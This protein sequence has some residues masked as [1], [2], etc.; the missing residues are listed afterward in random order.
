MFP[1]FMNPCW[2]P[3]GESCSPRE[4]RERKLRFLKSMRDELEAKLA[5][6]NASIETM[7]RQMS[8]DEQSV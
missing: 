2:G 6:L 7:E 1:F 8:Q 4:S 3:S 5:G